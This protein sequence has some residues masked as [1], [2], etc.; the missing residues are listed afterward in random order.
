MEDDDVLNNIFNDLKSNKSICT[1]PEFKEYVNL[2]SI[3][4]HY[5]AHKK[6]IKDVLKILLRPFYG[7]KILV[8]LI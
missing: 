6:N 5:I 3:K 7:E 8:Y 4:R 1:L 2:D